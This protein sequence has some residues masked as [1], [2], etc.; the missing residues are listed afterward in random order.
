MGTM[1]L[2]SDYTDLQKCF[3]IALGTGIKRTGNYNG[4]RTGSVSRSNCQTTKQ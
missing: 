2:S 4:S 3:V 1:V